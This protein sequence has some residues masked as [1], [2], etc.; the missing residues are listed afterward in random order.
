MTESPSPSLGAPCDPRVLVGEDQ[1]LIREGVVHVLREAG[2]DVVAVAAD[3]EDLVRKARAHRLDVVVT[4]IQMPPDHADDGL[5]AAREIR[6]LKPSVGVL[7]LTQF[8]E[9]RY[10]LELVGDRPEG[11]GYLL[12]DRVGDVA[13]FTEAVRRV[14]CGEAVLDPLV[15]S[16]LVGRR[17]AHNPVDE[18][19]PREREVLAFVAEGRSNQGIADSLVVTVSAVE[20]HITSI[21]GTLGLKPSVVDHRRVLAVLL[22]LKGERASHKPP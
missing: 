16:R 1:P 12:K 18:L 10:A 2:F 4:D 17:R 5:R 14:A 15:V 21:F 6:S 22:Y 11:V 19:S 7:V 8:L 20:R 13:T 3:A 9:D